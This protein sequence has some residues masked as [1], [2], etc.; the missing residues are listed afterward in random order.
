MTG[1]V[2][3]GVHLTNASDEDCSFTFEVDP[4]GDGSW[5]TYG[6]IPV[7]ARGY[8]HHAFPE[9]FSAHWVRVQTDRATVATVQFFYTE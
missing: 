3:K 2:R 7:P 1:F 8:V 4:L 9:A 5:E 6:R